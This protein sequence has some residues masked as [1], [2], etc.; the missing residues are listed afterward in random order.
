MKNT[1][2]L[3]TGT[4]LAQTHRCAS[5]EANKSPEANANIATI[6]PIVTIATVAAGRENAAPIAASATSVKAHPSRINADK[7]SAAKNKSN[8]S[9][10]IFG[11]MRTDLASV[12]SVEWLRPDWGDATHHDDGY[13]GPVWEVLWSNNPLRF[14]D[15]REGGRCVAVRRDL[16]FDNL[17]VGI[18]GMS[19]VEARKCTW[20]SVL[21]NHQMPGFKAWLKGSRWSSSRPR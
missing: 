6:V 21:T 15:E 17:E 1:L 8:G 14:G 18:A 16:R 3:R 13:S 10:H 11:R 5:V 4:R 12:A 2:T 7:V 20:V 9:G 19:G